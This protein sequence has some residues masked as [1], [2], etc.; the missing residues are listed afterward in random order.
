MRSRRHIRRTIAAVL[1]VAMLTAGLS[2]C[3][4]SSS[5]SSKL[6]D[7]TYKG[8]ELSVYTWPEY[9]PDSVLTDF[10][11]DY[12]VKVNL[13]TYDS[14]EEM[15]SK[16]Q[17]SAAGTYDIVMPSDYMVAD[18]IKDGLLAKLDRDEIKNFSNLDKQYLD[19]EY[20]P[21]N[22]Y[23]VPFSPGMGIPCY[24][25]SV[26]G[27]GA[28]TKLSDLFDSKY[29]N[30]I[31]V[32]DEVKEIIGMTNKS[33][34]YSLNETDPDK[35]ENTRKKLEQLKKNVYAM[36][37]E[38]TQE[39]LVNGEVSVGYMYNGNV[40]MGQLANDNIVP[41]WPEEGSYKWVDNICVLKSSSKQ[42]LANFFINYILDADVDV[43]IRT[44]IPSADPNA[45]GW[46][47][48]DDKYKDTALVIPKD[49]WDKSEY[50]ATLDDKTNELYTQMWTEFTQ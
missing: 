28:I 9:I 23:S 26:L 4:S 40:A 37:I 24:D 27:D 14:N 16:V 7:D 39:Y 43:K 48:M 41:V 20:D 12:G 8:M 25:K 17:S 15:L 11:N 10:Q 18:M 19:Q 5:G 36:T 42:D 13:T 34:G 44:E 22:V 33:L 35:L 29:K 6:K 2:G 3:G 31:V 32:L 21:D 46:A 38:A 49:C 1:S 30:D 50:A 47:L 45:A